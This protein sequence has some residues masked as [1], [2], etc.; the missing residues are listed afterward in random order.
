VDFLEAIQQ[1]QPFSLACDFLMDDEKDIIKNLVNKITN[2]D[3]S[4]I[5]MKFKK[6]AQI[7]F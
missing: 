7:D 1:V 2:S 6:V 3:T 4:N 5:K